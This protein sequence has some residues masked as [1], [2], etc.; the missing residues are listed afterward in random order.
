MIVFF[1]QKDFISSISNKEELQRVLATDEALVQI[2]YGLRFNTQM[3]EEGR[4]EPDLEGVTTWLRV[5]VY[6][7]RFEGFAAVIAASQMNI[8]T[9]H[10]EGGD[11]TEGGALDD[12][13]RHAMSKLSHIHFTT[14]EQASNRILAM[15]EEDWR[16]HTVGFPA[17]D[18]ISEGNYATPEE[19]VEKLSLDLSKPIVLF[20]QHSIT[21]EFDD[22]S[23]QVTPSL[24]AMVKLANSV[25]SKSIS[26]SSILLSLLFVS[27][28]PSTIPVS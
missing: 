28:G 16:V 25:L 20:T 12:S 24:D 13:V 2:V 22:A 21:T 18:L 6:A 11:L 23:M 26:I 17:I 27:N 15:G 5:V 7:D 4:P 3:I 19:I 14:N 8:P 1:G 9:A 10:I